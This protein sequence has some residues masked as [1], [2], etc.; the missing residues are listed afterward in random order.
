MHCVLKPQDAI[1]EGVSHGAESLM[2]TLILPYPIFSQPGNQ[3][4]CQ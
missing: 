4:A 3:N 2:R 1:W